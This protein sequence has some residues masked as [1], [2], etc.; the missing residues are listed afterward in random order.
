MGQKKRRVISVSE[1]MARIRKH[2]TRPEMILRK[3]L[4]SCGIRYRLRYKLTGSPDLVIVGLRLA[5]FVDGCFWHRCPIHYRAPKSNLD[6][7]LPKIDRNTKR[8]QR[9]NAEL[10]ETGWSVLRLWEHEVRN[11]SAA[12]VERVVES[13][14]AARRSLSTSENGNRIK[15][16]SKLDDGQSP[17]R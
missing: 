16:R 7:W 12:A 14:E 4:W 3:A 13:I 10:A 8:D 15:G 5:I 6:Y 11:D 9:V 2:D 1:Q 17:A